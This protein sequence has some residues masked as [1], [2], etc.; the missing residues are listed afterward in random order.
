MIG[1]EHLCIDGEKI[2]ANANYRKSKNL[3]GL[4]TEYEHIKK[5]I[6]KLLEK[7]PIVKYRTPEI[8]AMGSI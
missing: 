3:E 2:Q 7:E 4:K 1:F 6:E 8:L 5:G